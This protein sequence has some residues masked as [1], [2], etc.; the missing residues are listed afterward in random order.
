MDRELR[1]LETH[2][3]SCD[4]ALLP[5]TNECKNNDQIVKVLRKDLQDHLTNKCPRRQYQ[6]PHCEEMGEHQERM[7]SHLQTCPKVKVPCPNAQCQVSISRCKVSAHRSTCDYE[8]VSCKYAEVG[9]EER[10]LRKDL[11]SHEK[12]AQLHFRVTTD[13]VLDLSNKVAK[14]EEDRHHLQTEVTA[15]KTML[16]KANPFVFKMTSFNQRKDKTFYS[17]PLYTS[18]TGYKMCVEVV[19]NGYGDGIGNGTHVSVFADL[20]KGDNDDSLTWPFTGTVTFELLNQLEDKNHHKWTVTFPADSKVSQRVVNGER[21]PVGRGYPQFISHTALDHQP[22][23]N[24]RYLV[25]D[26]LT[27]RVLYKLLTTS[28]GWSV[29]QTYSRFS[30]VL[31]LIICN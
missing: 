9:C 6:C 17:P 2:L 29:A 11:K 26:S 19:A 30:D 28:P 24:S 7:T 10:P 22:A 27:F 15:L 16:S 21:A 20:M 25:D 12:D 13:K 3:Q 4:Y 1:E 14:Y 8:P 23:I 31:Q 5:C 18:P